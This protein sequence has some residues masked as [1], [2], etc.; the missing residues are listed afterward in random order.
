MALPSANRGGGWVSDP[1]PGGE[2]SGGITLDL[3]ESQLAD[4]MQEAWWHL[5]VKMRGATD[6]NS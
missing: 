1:R 5:R 2:E 4:R 6:S 3:R